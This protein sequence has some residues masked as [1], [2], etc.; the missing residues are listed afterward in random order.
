MTGF[1]IFALGCVVVAAALFA[2]AN[3]VADRHERG[4][5]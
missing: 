1:A 2:V 5:R 3:A 4:G